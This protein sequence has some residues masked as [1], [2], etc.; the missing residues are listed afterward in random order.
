MEV[1]I[2]ACITGGIT[3][4]GVII[5]NNKQSAVMEE[6]IRGVRKDVET[7][8]NRVEKHNGVIERVFKLE[9]QP[10]QCEEKFKTLFNDISRLDGL[11]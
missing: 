11:K 3:L 7:L 10:S 5:A 1:I 9:E 4:F 8:A 6:Q 2:A